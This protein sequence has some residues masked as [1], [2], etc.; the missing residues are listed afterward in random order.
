MSFLAGFVFIWNYSVKNG[1]PI[2]FLIMPTSFPGLIL[3][4]LIISSPLTGGLKI[5][6]RVLLLDL[7]QLVAYKLKFSRC[8][9]FVA[10]FFGNIS[11]TKH[12]EIIDVITCLKQEPPYS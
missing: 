3:K 8:R 6:D 1:F 5:P 2:A 4:V 10:S 9:A 11:L 7:L 12:H